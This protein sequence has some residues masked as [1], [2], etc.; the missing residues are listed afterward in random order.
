M[1]F[2]AALNDLQILSVDIGNA[3]LNALNREKVYA[4]AGKEFGSKARQTVI[5]IQAL[6][7]LKSAGVA[8]RSHLASSLSSLGYQSCLADPDI[9]LRAAVK[10]DKTPYY[11][12]LAVYVDDTLFISENPSTTMTAT[13]KI[14]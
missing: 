9:W 6:Y 7:G 14:Y 8:W 5:I 13:S 3:S 10:G 2:I 4:T 11:E 12:Y 1:F